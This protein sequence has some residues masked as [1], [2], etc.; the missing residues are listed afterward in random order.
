MRIFLC[1]VGLIAT[2]S[3]VAA[4]IVTQISP[5]T[6]PGLTTV[7]TNLTPQTTGLVAPRANAGVEFGFATLD[8]AT[9]QSSNGIRLAYTAANFP[10]ADV[11]LAI[12]MVNDGTLGALAEIGPNSNDVLQASASAYFLDGLTVTTTGLPL[13][14]PELLNL[15]V[16]VK[17]QITCDDR[18]GICNSGMVFGYG[19]GTLGSNTAVHF[20]GGE[21]PFP[22]PLLTTQSLVPLPFLNGQPFNIALQ[23][24]STSR[25][26]KVDAVLQNPSDLSEFLYHPMRVSG[27]SVTD[28]AGHAESFSIVST[29]G[30]S[31][32]T[33]GI[34]TPEPGTTATVLLGIGGICILRRRWLLR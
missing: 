10:S 20:I 3:L 11:A 23:I 8:P 26:Y 1:S 29:S 15:E 34:S 32:G 9:A 25:L 33:S 6:Q 30:L 24:I 28:N 18:R 12:A 5:F 27:I 4:T 22:G 16:T 13:G 2:G 7:Q 21:Q 14:A 31:Y 19:A 17:G